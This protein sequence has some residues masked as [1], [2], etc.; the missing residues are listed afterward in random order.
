[1]IV[2]RRH[3][4]VAE[5]A[6]ARRESVVVAGDEAGIAE[7]AEVL[8]RIEREAA[9]QPQ[10][11]DA[12]SAVAG[13]DGLGR[14]LD[15]RHPAGNGGQR[16]HVHRLSE[17]V[18]GNDGL[19]LRCHRPAHRIDVQVVGRRV[20]VDQHRPR[21]EP[22]HASGGGEERKR[23]RDHLVAFADAGRHQRHQQRVGAR[24]YPD[25][26]RHLEV[27]G[28]FALEGEDFLAHDAAL[29][30]AHPGDGLEE[31]VAQ[32]PV[33]GLEVEKRD[34]LGHDRWA[35]RHNRPS[36]RGRPGAH[37]AGRCRRPP[38]S[39]R[40]GRSPLRAPSRARGGPWPGCQSGGP[41]RPAA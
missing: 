25:C 10:S 20:D 7:R 19:G 8:G 37:G 24:R 23:R 21:A 34:R 26:V 39:R 28:E 41:P 33:L 16:R 9:G 4:V 40:A 1:M 31:L 11:A 14:V 17:Q 5:Q 36:P 22:G 27:V 38:S 29:A 35:I 12:A 6:H 2:A 32:R 30:V 3:A 15:E 13:A 18:H